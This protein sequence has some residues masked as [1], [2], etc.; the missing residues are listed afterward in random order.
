MFQFQLLRL[1]SS[2]TGLSE[3]V[4][5]LK[6]FGCL[7]D[8]FEIG[9]KGNIEGRERGCQQSRVCIKVQKSSDNAGG[10]SWIHAV[11]HFIRH[12]TFQIFKRSI[13]NVYPG[14]KTAFYVIFNLP[15]VF[16]YQTSFII[17]KS[18]IKA[19]T[20]NTREAFT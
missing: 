13:A 5:F 6:T 1:L 19:L 4:L 2:C 17:V 7:Y 16:A 20:E 9:E 8:A 12:E 10:K 15:N 18:F 14:N 3:T 11:S